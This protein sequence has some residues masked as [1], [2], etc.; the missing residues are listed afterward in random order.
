MEL[1]VAVTISTVVALGIVSFYLFSINS[2]ASTSNYTDLNARSRYASDIISRD[3]RNSNC[4]GYE[5]TNVLMLNLQNDPNPVTYAYDATAG[6][7][8]R[9]QNTSTR[10][11]LR[12][13]ISLSWNLYQL[14]TNGAGYGSF[15]PAGLAVDAKFISFQWTCSRPLSGGQSNSA[16]LQTAMVELRN[17]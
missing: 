1:L 4:V 15:P 11:L 6:T 13:I 12:G 5:T 14:P 16:S 2:F 17:R 8:Q 10:T 9:G 3:I 7:L